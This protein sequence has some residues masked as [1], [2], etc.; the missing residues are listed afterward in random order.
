[1][2]T[3]VAVSAVSHAALLAIIL[4]GFG[5]AKELQPQTVESISV[6]LVPV[7]DVA[8]IRAGTLNSDVV[9]T[10]TPSIVEDDKPAEIAKPTGNT[11]EDQPK[12]EATKKPTPLPTTNSAPA[13]QPDPVPEPAPRPAAPPPPVTPAPQ[14]EPEPQETAAPPPPAPAADPQPAPEP[15]APAPELATPTEAP[16]PQDVAPQPATRVANLE[17]KRAAFAKQQ[18]AKKQAEAEAKKKA[19]EEAKKQADAEAKKKADDAA[20]KKAEDDKRKADEAKR[21]ADAKDAKEK[22]EREAAAKQQQQASLPTPDEISDLINQDTSRGSVTGS[23]GSPTLGKPTGTA[24][25]LSQSDLSALVSRIKSCLRSPLGAREAGAKANLTI[26]FNPDGSVKGQP[27]ITEMG[28]TSMDLAWANASVRA[29]MTCGPYD[30]VAQ[31]YDQLNEIGV[32][33]DATKD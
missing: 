23:G 8:S 19:D 18:E 14:P 12:P 31:K 21:L 27:E 32:L 30:I 11:E 4:V 16:T 20:K 7:T 15:V 26:R 25:T 17:E 6:D 3:G 13:P 10:K 28:V 2:K 22:A 9:D 29:V 1:M 33:F 24:A 5:S